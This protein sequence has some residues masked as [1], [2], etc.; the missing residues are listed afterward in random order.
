M[1]DDQP[2][3]AAGAAVTAVGTAHGDVGLAPER[4]AARSPI[5]SL[6]VEPTLIDELRHPCRLEEARQSPTVAQATTWRSMP[7]AAKTAGQ[8]RPTFAAE[9]AIRAP[10]STAAA[11]SSAAKRFK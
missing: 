9:S 10:W 3:V 6:D 11:A 2:H 7:S 1:V 4:H 5:A 8:V